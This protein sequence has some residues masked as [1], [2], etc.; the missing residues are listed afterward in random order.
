[1]E[2]EIVYTSHIKHKQKK[3]NKQFEDLVTIRRQISLIKQLCQINYTLVTRNKSL[4]AQLDLRDQL[5]AYK[6]IKIQ[7]V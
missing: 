2:L 3:A 6:I 7:T 1:M 4:T 5:N